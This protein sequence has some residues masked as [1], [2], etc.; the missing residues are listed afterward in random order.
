MTYPQ[1][2]PASP[3]SA[4][5][6]RRRVRIGAWVAAAAVVATGVTTAIVLAADPGTL[7]VRGTLT[8][9]DGGTHVDDLADS[10]E[11]VCAGD[12]GY[13]DIAAGAQVTIY[14]NHAAILAAGVL[15]AGVQDTTGSTCIFTFTVPEVPAGHDIYQVEVSHRGK[16]V[17]TEDTAGVVM[18]SLGDPDF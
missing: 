9:F 16:V 13:S 18:L 3:Q 12:G 8:L 6:R 10:G 15:A 4:P 1:P 5:N 7:D 2:Y 17:F 14:D 11:W